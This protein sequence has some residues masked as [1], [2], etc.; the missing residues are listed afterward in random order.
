[1]KYRVITGRSNTKSLLLNTL[2]DGGMMQ[3]SP[4]MLLAHLITNLCGIL[5]LLHKRASKALAYIT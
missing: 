3:I 5:L 1:M 4:S 2:L